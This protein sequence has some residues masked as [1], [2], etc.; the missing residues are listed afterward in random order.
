MFWMLY[1]AIS[2]YVG[3]LFTPV[4]AAHGEIVCIKG[5]W[6]AREYSIIHHIILTNGPKISCIHR[7]RECVYLFIRT[8][9]K[10]DLI[11]CMALALLQN[12]YRQFL[13]MRMRKIRKRF[14]KPVIR[15]FLHRSFTFQYFSFT[16]TLPLFVSIYPRWSCIK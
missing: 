4:S 3:Y 8:L 5:K 13:S 10:D 9:N 16:P 1:N 7:S 11:K 12:V 15:L 2:L 14:S 6:K